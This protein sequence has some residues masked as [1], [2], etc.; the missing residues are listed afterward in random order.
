MKTN[1]SKNT[2]SKKLS[3]VIMKEIR[4]KRF[5]PYKIYWPS[6]ILFSFFSVPIT[7][8]SFNF[9]IWILYTAYSSKVLKFLNLEVQLNYT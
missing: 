8:Q 2:F 6:F 7:S 4:V 1:I 3:F 5:S 9:V